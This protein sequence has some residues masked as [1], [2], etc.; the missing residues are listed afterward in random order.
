MEPMHNGNPIQYVPDIATGKK[1]HTL[2]K[3]GVS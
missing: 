2:V 1:I 3:F